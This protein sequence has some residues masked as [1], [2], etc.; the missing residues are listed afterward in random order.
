MSKVGYSFETVQKRSTKMEE[1]L[2]GKIYEE[3]L[4]S[5]G[6]SNAEQKS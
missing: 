6:L 4:R 2:K 5:L 1:G 3:Q